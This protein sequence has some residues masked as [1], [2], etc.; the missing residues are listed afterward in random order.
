MWIGTQGL[1]LSAQA[2]EEIYVDKILAFAL[3]RVRIKNRDL[4]DLLWLKQQHIKPALELLTSKL[5][6]HQKTKEEFLELANN[7]AQSLVTDAQLK[8][9]FRREMQCFLPAK[10]V[11]ETVNN[12]RFWT[13][14]SSEIPSLIREVEIFL[15]GRSKPS[16][17]VM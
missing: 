14:L 15:S 10:I 2:L 1:I 4:W 3:R 11:N 5:N 6:D 17:F 9:D 7:R 16:D 13:Y 12:D 8:K